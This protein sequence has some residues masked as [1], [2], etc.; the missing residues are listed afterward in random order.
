VVG[1]IEFGAPDPNGAKGVVKGSGFSNPECTVSVS[2]A[3]FL[4]PY[5]SSGNIVTG[6]PV[7]T[8]CVNTDQIITITVTNK[9]DP[10]QSVTFQPQCPNAL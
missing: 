9:T 3:G 4:G 6:V 1:W 8:R 5:S 10:S 2:Q 7:M